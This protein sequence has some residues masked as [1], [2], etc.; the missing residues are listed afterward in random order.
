MKTH[1]KNGHLQNEENSRIAVKHRRLADGSVREF[2]QLQC[3]TCIQDY[4]RRK[5]DKERAW[6]AALAAER[7][8][9]RKAAREAFK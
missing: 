4:G 3:T 1:C 8:A 6:R 2:M 5:R 9:K 7:V